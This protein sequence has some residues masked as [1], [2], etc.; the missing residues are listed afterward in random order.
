MIKAVAAVIQDE[1]GNI[2]L[3]KRQL[4]RVGGGFWEFPGGKIEKNETP[5]NALLRELVEELGDKAQIGKEVL[6][7]VVYAYPWGTVEIS[8]YFAKL[9]TQNLT[10]VADSEFCWVTPKKAKKMNVLAATRPVLE[11]LENEQ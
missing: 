4:K 2:L 10:T 3:G 11:V 5:K 9:Q 8:F 7:A 1:Q 6:P